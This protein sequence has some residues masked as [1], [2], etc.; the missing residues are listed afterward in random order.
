[1]APGRFRAEENGCSVAFCNITIARERSVSG[2]NVQGY[3]AAL[4]PCPLLAQGRGCCAAYR[5]YSLWLGCHQ[6]AF[7]ELVEK[8]PREDQKH[9]RRRAI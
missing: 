4:P 6:W 9:N 3:R 7:S 8:G 2:I 1:M 5:H